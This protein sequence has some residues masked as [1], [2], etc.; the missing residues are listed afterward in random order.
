MAFSCGGQEALTDTT[1]APLANKE[2]GSGERY[3]DDPDYIRGLALIKEN[4]CPNCHTRNS[5][6]IGPSYSEIAS[7][8]DDTEATISVL[9]A[10]IITGSVGIWGEIPMTEHPSLSPEKA[11]QMIKYILS[12]KD[13]S[14]L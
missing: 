4:D 7:K 1:N 13:Q 12:L 2:A 5:S 11:A 3:L 10:R 14:I 6:M 8:Y 9:T